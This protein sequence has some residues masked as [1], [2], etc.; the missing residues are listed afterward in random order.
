[1][2]KTYEQKNVMLAVISPNATNYET[3]STLSPLQTKQQYVD[4]YALPRHDYYV[5]NKFSRDDYDIATTYYNIDSSKFMKV[6]ND[7]ANIKSDKDTSGNTIENSKRN[8]IIK[9]VNSQ[10][11]SGIQQI[12]LYHLA[13]YSVKEY[14]SQ[15]YA[16]INSLPINNSEKQKLWE[17]LG[18]K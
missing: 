4:Y 1:M 13:G 7:M 16:Y 11:L 3:I 12:Y 6:V 8:K 18:F 5:S 14:K 2:T 10:N 15:L 9:Y 17:N